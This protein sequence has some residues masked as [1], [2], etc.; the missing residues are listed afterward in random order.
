M[1]CYT[2]LTIFKSGHPDSR[3]VHSFSFKENKDHYVQR[4]IPC[5]QCIGCRLDKSR[6]W[7]AR[8]MHENQMHEHSYFLTLTLTDENLKSTSTGAASLHPRQLE[9]FWKRLRKYY[10]SANIRYYAV[11]EYG[12]S[13]GRPHYHAI[14]F[15]FE[16]SDLLVYT[17]RSG[18]K[19]YT[20]ENLDRLWGL[21]RV[22]IGHV[23]F[24]SCA[25]VARYV[26]KKLTGPMAFLYAL[27]D[28]YP[29]FSR[30][31]RGTRPK[32]GKPSTGGI[33]SSWYEHFKRDLFPF[34]KCVIRN[35]TTISTPKYY[36]QKLKKQNPDEYH[37][38]QILRETRALSHADDNTTKRREAKLEVK[39]QQLKSLIRG[40][41]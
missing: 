3:G 20:S 39:L 40:F 38:L 15:G 16:L 30:M 27:D 8:L 22:W 25:Y 37:A 28:L 26:L 35:G 1:P 33:G 31:S 21:G 32:D 14:V 18:I 9:L 4:E 41:L 6:T 2:P 34:D 19:L 13:T 24:E 11:G 7:A 36:T 23:T 12:D 5:G 17:Q 10:P 29:E